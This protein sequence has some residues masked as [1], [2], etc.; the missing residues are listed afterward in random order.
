[1]LHCVEQLAQHR[2]ALGA[3]GL[4]IQP[5]VQTLPVNPFHYYAASRNRV[6]LNAFDADNIRMVERH[7]DAIFLI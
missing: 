6:V 5:L 2:L 1:M 7:A 4:A 3:R